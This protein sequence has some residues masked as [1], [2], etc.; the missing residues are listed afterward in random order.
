[1]LQRR[2][3]RSASQ[4]KHF[5]LARRERHSR[6]G[7]A[8][9]ERATQA[10]GNEAPAGTIAVDLCS[11][12]RARWRRAELESRPGRCREMGFEARVHGPAF[13][14]EGWRVLAE[15]GS[16]SLLSS[17]DLIQLSFQHGTAPFDLTV[18]LPFACSFFGLYRLRT[19]A[20]LY[21]VQTLS[22]LSP[23]RKTCCF[24]RWQP[25]LSAAVS[26][27]PPISRSSNQTL[28]TAATTTTP[29]TNPRHF[30]SS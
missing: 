2:M 17:R 4:C 14:D 22:K 20:S 7:R 18:P 15:L 6:V 16:P 10:T 1:M 29:T 28:H 3:G 23:S 21:C 19:H 12:D 5:S 9:Q 26:P 27:K 8:L 13:Y 25:S 24:T 11:S 30:V